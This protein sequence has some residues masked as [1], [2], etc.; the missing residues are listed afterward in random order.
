MPAC[1]LQAGKI[2]PE[3]IKQN[4]KIRRKPRRNILKK[5]VMQRQN[6]QNR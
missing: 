5:P 2:Y 6:W 4:L 3:F 1:N